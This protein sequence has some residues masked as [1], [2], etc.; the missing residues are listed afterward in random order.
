MDNLKQTLREKTISFWFRT[1]LRAMAWVILMFYMVYRILIPV[2][3]GE[4]T[5]I[6]GNDGYIMLGCI[7]LLLAVEGVKAAYEKWIASRLK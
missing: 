4:P 7:G 2:I 1:A 5:F 6:D 3:N